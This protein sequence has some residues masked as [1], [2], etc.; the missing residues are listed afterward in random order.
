MDIK[1]HQGQRGNIVTLTKIMTVFFVFMCCFAN[2]QIVFLSERTG[3]CSK[4]HIFF[5]LSTDQFSEILCTQLLIVFSNLPYRR[6]ATIGMQ[7]VNV[8]V[9]LLWHSDLVSVQS[10]SNLSLVKD[11]CWIWKPGGAMS[12]QSTVYSTL[13]VLDPRYNTIHVWPVISCHEEGI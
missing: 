4:L 5:F 11:R 3:K 8:T 9:H 10:H 12:G 6:N 7:I 1:S 13:P 2:L